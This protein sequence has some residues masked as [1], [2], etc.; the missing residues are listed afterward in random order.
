SV[1]ASHAANDAFASERPYA[2]IAGLSWRDNH[3]AS[4]CFNEALSKRN[5]SQLNSK[6]KHLA[7]LNYQLAISLGRIGAE[8]DLAL[9]G[10]LASGK[11][12][13]SLRLASVEA[14][15]ELQHPD[16]T[17][18]LT[19][20]NKPLSTKYSKIREKTALA[21]SKYTD[22]KAISVLIKRLGQEKNSRV[23]SAIRAG[24]YQRTG[25][26]KKNHREWSK[27]WK[28][29]EDKLID[30]NAL[31]K[32]RGKDVR[33]LLTNEVFGIPSRGVV[34]LFLLDNSMSMG[35]DKK[36]ERAVKELQQALR[37]LLSQPRL[38]KKP[39]FF[40]VRLF[41][42]SSRPLLLD[43]GIDFFEVN[44]ANINKACALL[45]RVK[46][47]NTP[48]MI[49]KAFEQS[50]NL[51]K[52]LSFDTIYLISDGMPTFGEAPETEN[53]SYRVSVL[54]RARRAVIHTIGVYDGQRPLFLDTRRK[55]KGD[56]IWKGFLRD[57]A[58]SNGGFFVS[59]YLIIKK[60]KKN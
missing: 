22:P 29:F 2:F 1:L 33:P 55:V 34:S 4:R 37:I 31:K 60:A 13:P 39:R 43:G 36:F 47:E 35:R 27:W 28:E 41:S 12:N 18:V 49:S 9:L 8:E 17:Q 52:K 51:R 11:V 24:L 10:Q 32:F 3:V 14:I 59:N 26:N 53:I 46:V 19:K 50:F 30:A 40:N 48:T 16:V 44:P 42:N 5:K 25:L 15:G 38:N 58:D 6:K 7:L 21:I 20:L 45:N 54:N 56:G 23:S 57:L